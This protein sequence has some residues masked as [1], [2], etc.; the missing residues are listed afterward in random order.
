MPHC[1]RPSP[2][3][4]GTGSGPPCAGRGQEPAPC[5]GNS[6]LPPPPHS[7]AVAL[8]S[9]PGTNPFSKQPR[10]LRP[11]AGGVL[12]GGGKKKPPPH[13]AH[14]EVFVYLLKSR[15][16]SPQPAWGCFAEEGAISTWQRP[17]P[18]LG[19]TSPS[20]GEEATLRWCPAPEPA[21]S[22]S[23]S[24]PALPQETA[25]QRMHQ[26]FPWPGNTK[27]NYCHLLG[28]HRRDI[29]IFIYIFSAARLPAGTTSSTDST[30]SSP[31]RRQHTACTNPCHGHGLHHLGSR[32]RDHS[33][34]GHSPAP[35]CWGSAPPQGAHTMLQKES[36]AS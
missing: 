30:V 20:W 21:L 14:S 10:C 2:S 1:P 12:K 24:P 5:F 28:A 29:F 26:P 31:A 6:P 23:G 34:A 19:P 33:R 11:R 7:T 16:L 17:P 8:N 4:G 18:Q 25:Q 36:G 15:F 13:R 35:P 3:P 32:T 27:P 9:S 22:H